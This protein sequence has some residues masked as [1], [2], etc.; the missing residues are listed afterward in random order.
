MS[1][2]DGDLIDVETIQDGVACGAD[3]DE[4]LGDRE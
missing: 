3:L 4:Y 1:I 2:D